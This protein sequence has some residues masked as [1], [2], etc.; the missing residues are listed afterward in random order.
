MNNQNDHAGYPADSGYETNMDTGTR[1][2]RLDRMTNT[3]NGNQNNGSVS[4]QNQHDQNTDN[5]RIV[6]N[7][8]GQPSGRQRRL[9]NQTVAQQE[10]V[11][12]ANSQ[13]NTVKPQVYDRYHQTSN[14]Q[15]S[16]GV[17]FGQA[18]GDHTPVREY[19][20]STEQWRTQQTG[21]AQPTGGQIP[22]KKTPMPQGVTN[23]GHRPISD[24]QKTDPALRSVNPWQQS[25]ETMSGFSKD[26]VDPSIAQDRSPNLYDKD[27]RFWGKAENQQ[28]QDN[29]RKANKQPTQTEDIKR[30]VKGILILV[31][32]L[33]IAALIAR[34]TIFSVNEITVMGNETVSTS[35]IIRWSGVRKGTYLLTVNEKDIR[36]SLAIEPKIELDYIE[37]GVP[38]H[39]TIAVKERKPVAYFNDCGIYYTVD[40]GR[41]VLAESEDMDDEQYSGLFELK[42]LSLKDTRVGLKLQLSDDEQGVIYESLIREIR[43]MQWLPMILEIDLSDLDSIRLMT[44]DHYSIVIGD[45]QNIHAKLRAMTL[46]R[47]KLISMGLSKGTIDV[48][49]YE[50]PFYL[51]SV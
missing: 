12:K 32:V 5:Q 3:Y 13:S 27:N 25:N 21:Y 22:V 30:I 19:H 46:V 4:E 9:Q 17:V 33:V 15:V 10:T 48:S 38:G 41:M 31:V 18:T 26:D 28:K 42:G 1:A 14:A 11:D 23:E 35:D 36:N 43:V 40:K 20:Q 51:P 49:D 2:R 29:E 7:D 6:L 50:H 44:T 16:S 8:S 34:Y 24:W 47:E 37:K 39:V 45:D